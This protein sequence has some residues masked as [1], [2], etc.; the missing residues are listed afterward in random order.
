MGFWDWIKDTGKRVV[1]KVKEAVKGVKEL[2][3]DSSSSTSRDIGEENSYDPE[4]AKMEE[5]IRINDKLN[6]Y[7][8]EIEARSD[9]LENDVLKISRNSI[10]S[11]VDSLKKINK[12]IYAGKTLSINIER[13]LRENRSMEDNIHGHIK[14]YVQ[15]RVS[16][17][18]S[19]CLEILKRE[20]GHEK[21][22]EMK[23]FLD[24]VLKEVMDELIKKIKKIIQE[25]SDNVSD[26]IQS[27]INDIEM[28]SINTIEKY[29]NIEK[30]KE[31]NEDGFEAEIINLGYNVSICDRALKEL[32][33]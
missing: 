33:G 8:R 27:R 12:K 15:K 19:E 20:K 24:K 21:G 7:R 3:S 5:T 31:N 9:K 28:A 22:C 14:K 17:D 16:I 18:D 4:K 26:H 6:S 29:K 13:M 30:L 10:D 11:L 2:F 23:I 25:Q 32:K 1:D